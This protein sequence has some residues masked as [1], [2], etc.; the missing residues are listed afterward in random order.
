MS[1]FITKGFEVLED[2]GSV[3][4]DYFIRDRETGLEILAERVGNGK[5][6][7]EIGP[8]EY[9]GSI[10]QIKQLFAESIDGGLGVDVEPQQDD[11]GE[12]SRGLWDC[13]HPAALIT[14]LYGAS[15]HLL[16]GPDGKRL[17]VLIKTTLDNWG[18]ADSDG[19]PDYDASR[20]EI[21]L[22]MSRTFDNTGKDPVQA[23]SGHS[24]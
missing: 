1:R 13:C 14:E 4:K 9:T 5:F 18:W 17:A 8:A 2:D 12:S 3:T 22:W 23:G 21:D 19:E 7:A 20:R 16:G 15:E 11:V 6:K 10:K 24:S